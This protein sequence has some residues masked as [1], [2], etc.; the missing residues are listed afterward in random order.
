[1]TRCTAS[2]CGPRATEAV[3][4]LGF[5]RRQ[6]LLAGGAS[7]VAGAARA[8]P[9]KGAGSITVAQILDASAGKQDVSRD[10]LIGSR[11]AWQDINARGGVRGRPVQHQS[12]EVDGSRE[13]VRAAI[14]SI[15]DNPS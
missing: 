7:V 12:V 9:G 13:S 2:S 1:F 8:Q 6:V 4:S 14:A 15:R 5:T 11:A 3:R 10:F